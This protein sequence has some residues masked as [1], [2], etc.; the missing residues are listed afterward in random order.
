MKYFLNMLIEKTH[1]IGK[2]FCYHF[3]I[4]IC[5]ECCFKYKILKKHTFY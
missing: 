1:L 5:D 3:N 4:L 2:N